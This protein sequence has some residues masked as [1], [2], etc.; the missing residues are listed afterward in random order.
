LLIASE[1]LEDQPA[2]APDGKSIAFV[3]T[4][5]GNADV[6]TLPFTPDK[7]VAMSAARDVTNDP[8]GDFRPAFSPDGKTL[9]FSSDRGLPVTPQANA[10]SITRLRESDIYSVDL[11]TLRTTRLTDAPGWDGSPAWS[12]DGKTL[13]FYSDRGT[14]RDLTNTGLFVM[15]A[16]G[17]NQHALAVADTAG[18][19]SPK[20]L[21][22][23]RIVFARRTKPFSRSSAF[24][25]PGAW[26]IVS[27]RADGSDL[28]TESD[29]GEN[30]YWGPAPA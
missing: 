12:P 6:Y 9:A 18:A 13:V 21:P 14:R 29:E 26:Q 27:V 23:G 10:P 3:G 20:F 24:D 2:F 7:T 8:G 25:E 5:S 30:N 11:A 4:A 1:A 19:L 15:N 17:S 16:D 22:N 28:Q